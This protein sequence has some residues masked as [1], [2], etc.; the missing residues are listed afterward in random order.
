MDKQTQEKLVNCVNSPDVEFCIV[1]LPSLKEQVLKNEHPIVSALP[2][3]M[4][5]AIL[6]VPEG[7]AIG[8]I[9]KDL[10]L[11]YVLGTIDDRH[12]YLFDRCD[13]RVVGKVDIST[14]RL[15]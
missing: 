6:S 7:K 14:N 11:K 13:I 4:K 2:A 9:E 12:R 15:K 3:G 1:P 8:P 5:A 10:V